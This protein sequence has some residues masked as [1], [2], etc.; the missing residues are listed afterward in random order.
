MRI[1]QAN[2]VEQDALVELLFELHTYYTSPSTT[3]R[4][5]VR[6]HLTG[7][8]LRADSPI[9]LIVAETSGRKVVALA[10]LVQLPS[11]VESVGPGRRQCPVKEVFVSKSHRGMRVGHDLMKWVTQYALIQ[12]CGRI[13]WNVMAP[14][15]EGI[16]FYERLGARPVVDR[17]SYRLS[18]QSMK[19][20]ASYASE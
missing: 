13:D 14:N 8:L 3:T 5:D 4:D 11:L 19:R 6:A 12:G 10:A 9:E 16:R 20:L 1:A 15:A 2:D 18:H 17:L 7:S